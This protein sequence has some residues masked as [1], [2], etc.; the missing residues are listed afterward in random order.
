MVFGNLASCVGGIRKPASDHR[1]GELGL[2]Q[3]LVL[4]MLSIHVFLINIDAQ[5]IQDLVWGVWRPVF[6]GIRK[7]ASD[8]R[9]SQILV[10]QP[11]VLFILS[12]LSIDVHN[13]KN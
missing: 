12:I 13:G 9:P 2:Q 10:Q 3:P 6:L 7:P 11:L 8:H 4:F 1:S 5:D